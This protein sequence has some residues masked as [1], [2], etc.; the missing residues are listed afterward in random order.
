MSDSEETLGKKSDISVL[1]VEDDKF[2]RGLIGEKLRKEHYTVFEAID[3]KEGL[4]KI[5]SEKPT[6]VLLD[7]VIPETDGFEFLRI[8]AEDKEVNATPII[9]LSNLGSKEDIERARSLGAKDFLVKANYTPSE[10]IA[11]IKKIISEVYL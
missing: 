10:I 6:I 7:L 3:G 9:V 11:E 2:L 5:K 1:I 8:I 4:E